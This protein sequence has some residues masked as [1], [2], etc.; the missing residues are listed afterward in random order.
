VL[1]ELPHRVVDS[2]P[3]LGTV[4]LRDSGGVEGVLCAAGTTRR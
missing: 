1:R 2:L 3:L 4:A